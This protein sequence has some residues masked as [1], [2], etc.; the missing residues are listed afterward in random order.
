MIVNYTI[1]KKEEDI[2]S[3]DRN[4]EVPRGNKS[5]HSNI[6][7]SLLAVKATPSKYKNITTSKQTTISF[8]GIGR[9]TQ[10]DPHVVL[11]ITK[12]LSKEE[13]REGWKLHIQAGCQNLLL[14]E[15]SDMQKCFS[16]MGGS[17]WSKSNNPG[18]K[19]TSIGGNVSQCG[20]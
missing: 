13:I 1:I 15:G 20:N 9:K 18:E 3:T 12:D 5:P 16:D 17:S 8:I 2:M 4:S 14:L 11:D 19:Q 7:N 10:A 6:F